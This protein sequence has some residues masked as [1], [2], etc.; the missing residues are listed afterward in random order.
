MTLSIQAVK[1]AEV[2]KQTF[3][4]PRMY[5]LSPSK[6]IMGSNYREFFKDKNVLLMYTT[7]LSAY[8][9]AHQYGVGLHPAL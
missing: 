2:D 8:K 6:N 4:T 3:G 9:Y 5:T 1:T 7:V